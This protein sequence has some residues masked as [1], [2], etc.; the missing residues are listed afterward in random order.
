MPRKAKHPHGPLSLT[1]EQRAARVAT[2]A[3][4]RATQAAKRDAAALA[5]STR[6]TAPTTTPPAGSRIPDQ[7]QKL[8]TS[9]SLNFSEKSRESEGDGGNGSE[10]EAETKTSE[11]TGGEGKGYGNEAGVAEKFSEKNAPETENGGESEPE[12]DHE[13]VRAAMAPSQGE[14]EKVEDAKDNTPKVIYRRA[15]LYPAQ[16]ASFFGPERWSLTEGTTKAGK[17]AGLIVWLGEQAALGKAD[18][19]FW[20]VAPVAPVAAIAYRRMAKAIPYAL[21]T[22]H[23]T[24]QR[25]T[26]VNG[27]HI[28]FKSGEKPD[29]L[30]GEDVYAAAIDEGSRLRE[31]SWHAVRTTLSAT[32]GKCRIIGNVKGRRN[33]FYRLCRKAESGAA[34]DSAYHKL[35]WRDAVAAGILDVAEVEDAKAQLPPAVFQEL[36]EAEASDDTGC[37][38][39]LKAIKDCIGPMSRDPV[40]AWGW[41]FARKHDYCAGIGLD[42][43]GRVAA[44]ERFQMPWKQAIP[45]IRAKTNRLPALVDSTGIGDVIL[46][47]LTEGPGN[48]EGYIF[49]PRSK[50]LLMESLAIDIQTGKAQFPDGPIANELETFEYE[51]TRT[52]VRYSAPEGMFDDCVCGLALAR[53]HAKN[54]HG[55]GSIAGAVGHARIPAFEANSLERGYGTREILIG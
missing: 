55:G 19:N 29:N 42:R 26:L 50:Q 47:V 8:A 11:R 41:D 46:G 52:G 23:D 12:V 10:S 38:F 33:W 34:R 24:L 22:T 13:L 5:D 35:T 4:G 25:I 6:S 30:Y 40:T 14:T 9:A 21:R 44:F 49:T 27:A 28:W 43:L 54:G 16:M 2:L 36:Y 31:E 7:F 3:R 51:Y 48:F 39:G 37:P 15:P 45:L 53:W 20:W 32:K 17:T 18:Q 1:P